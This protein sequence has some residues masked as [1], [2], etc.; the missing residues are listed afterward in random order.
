MRPTGQSLLASSSIGLGICIVKWLGL[1]IAVVAALAVG[2]G[3][4]DQGVT[5]HYRITFETRSEGEAKTHSGVIE[6]QYR[7][8]QRLSG[9]R[10]RSI[11]VR[12]EAI[13]IDLGI[14]GNIFA[15][16]AASE[17]NVRTNPEQIVLNAF[18]MYEPGSPTKTF[19]D[20]IATLRTLS[21]TREL[22]FADDLPR[23]VRFR[24]QNDPSTVEPV[25]PF[26]IDEHCDVKTALDQAT[27]EILPT[28]RWPFDM[29]GATI[30]S[31]RSGIER[32]LPWLT[33]FE[34]L[35][36]GKLF[37]SDNKLASKL[38]ASDFQRM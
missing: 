31:T 28:R 29:F 21:G 11:D 22:S 33:G 20:R 13:K 27:L 32:E 25:N 14:C 30:T 1:I 6:V 16:L 12:G 19:E 3:L 15:L 38:S 34:T 8:T 7:D 9:R 23:L 17:G 10:D 2:A 35:L 36:N 5:I 26:Q 24:D 4:R 37:Q 18:K